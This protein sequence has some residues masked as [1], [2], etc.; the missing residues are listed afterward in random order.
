MNLLR[1][2]SWEHAIYLRN[3]H[4]AVALVHVRRDDSVWGVVLM[5]WYLV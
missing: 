5:S 2:G 4:P 3:S 1:S